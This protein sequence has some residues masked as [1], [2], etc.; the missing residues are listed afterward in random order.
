V[1]GALLESPPSLFAEERRR[2]AGP[3][4]GRGLTLEER[5]ES[6]LRAVR[7][8]GRAECPVCHATMRAEA[9]AARCS[10]CGSTLS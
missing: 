2:G 3:A 9:G 6:A 8:D 5:L 1:T 10:G 7:A 4:G